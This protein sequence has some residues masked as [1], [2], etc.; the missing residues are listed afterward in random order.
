M[1]IYNKLN[2]FLA[3]QIQVTASLPW[4]SIRDRTMASKSWVAVKDLELGYYIGETIFI[5]IYIYIPIKVTF[6]SSNLESCISL[7]LFDLLRL[8]SRHPHSD[9]LN[10][11]AQIDVRYERR[12]GQAH[13]GLRA[14]ALA[15][16]FHSRHQ[17]EG[18]RTSK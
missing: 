18:G 3:T 16:P 15:Q 7:M 12:M 5:T 13:V 8:N 17:E 2:K 4:S 1:G 9:G 10:D 6:L 14:G 11:V